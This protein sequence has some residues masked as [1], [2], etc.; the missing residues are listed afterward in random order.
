MLPGGSEITQHFI[1][2]LISSNEMEG[3]DEVIL[4]LCCT[5]SEMCRDVGSVRQM[6]DRD[7]GLERWRERERILRNSEKVCHSPYV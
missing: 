5:D 7:G 3:G 4:A 1:T 2:E 6:C